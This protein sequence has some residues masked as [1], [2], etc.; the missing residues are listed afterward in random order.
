MP[1]MPLRVSLAGDHSEFNSCYNQSPAPQQTCIPRTSEDSSQAEVMHS[2]RECCCAF[3]PDSELRSA[4]RADCACC[5]L[6]GTLACWA[7]RPPAQ[8]G[9]A[10]GSQ[11]RTVVLSVL[12]GL[13]TVLPGRTH[14]G[15]HEGSQHLQDG[16]QAGRQGQG[17]G[18]Q[19]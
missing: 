12:A 9:G 3:F 15:R 6:L 8:S 4:E 14:H 7:H 11:L 2:K 16:A 17:E 5:C 18:R 19:L 1:V 13:P 10:A